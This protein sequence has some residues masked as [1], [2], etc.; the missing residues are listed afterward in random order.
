MAAA[1]TLPPFSP[2]KKQQPPPLLLPFPSPWM[3]T[4][5]PSKS[6]SNLSIKMHCPLSNIFVLL[7]H[8]SSHHRSHGILH[9]LLE[10]AM[11]L[12]RFM[13][14]T[15][16]SFPISQNLQQKLIDHHRCCSCADHG[17]VVLPSPLCD[18]VSYSP[19]MHLFDLL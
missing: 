13:E 2:Q 18:L 3:A 6:L 19:L 5:L 7:L 1:P 17:E 15:P 8:V 12:Q 16:M 10:D 14:V 9:I 11:V 4:P